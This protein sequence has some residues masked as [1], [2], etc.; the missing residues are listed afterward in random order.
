MSRTFADFCAFADWREADG[1][2]STA[3]PLAQGPVLLDDAYFDGVT[4]SMHRAASDS[5]GTR[6]VGQLM[7]DLDSMT[8]F[9]RARTTG[10]LLFGA[11]LLALPASGQTLG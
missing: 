2:T 9:G 3:G 1:E 6:A 10:R 8:S 4:D 7:G 5:M 11:E